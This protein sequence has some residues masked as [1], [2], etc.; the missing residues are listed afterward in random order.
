[1]LLVV[2]RSCWTI[3]SNF[4][5][6]KLFKK[7]LN[8]LGKSNIS[9]NDNVTTNTAIYQL[10]VLRDRNHEC[11]LKNYSNL[12]DSKI[13][14]TPINQSFVQLWNNNSNQDFIE[15]YLDTTVSTRTIFLD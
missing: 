11:L 7:Y 1:M 10:K 13:Q 12:T 14:F 8:Q 4:L 9:I 2:V 6:S 3:D 15:S 5:F